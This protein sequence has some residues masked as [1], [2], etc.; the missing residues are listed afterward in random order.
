MCTACARCSLETAV[1]ALSIPSV[2]SNLALATAFFIIWEAL[3]PYAVFILPVV[4]PQF[5]M[6]CQVWEIALWETCLPL[7]QHGDMSCRLAEGV[8]TLGVNS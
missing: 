7:P 6:Q 8:N 4:L 1:A 2:F 5:V 3:S